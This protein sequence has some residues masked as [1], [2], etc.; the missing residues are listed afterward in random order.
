MGIHVKKCTD[1]LS[2]IQNQKI[3]KKILNFDKLKEACIIISIYNVC[4]G[5]APMNIQALFIINDAIHNH[6]TRRNIK[7]V[8][9]KIRCLTSYT[10]VVYCR[11]ALLYI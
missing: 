3:K 11:I 4:C 2:K 5:K 10:M 8:H 6:F 7:F 1:A 9:R